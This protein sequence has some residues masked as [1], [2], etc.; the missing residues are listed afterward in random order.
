MYAK[1]YWMRP[2]DMKTQPEWP[3]SQMIGRNVKN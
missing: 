2:R 3:V 1:K